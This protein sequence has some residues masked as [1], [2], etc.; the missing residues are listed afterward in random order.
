MPSQILPHPALAA[1]REHALRAAPVRTAGGD[2][3]VLFLSHSDGEARATVSSACA[4]DGAGAW[5]RL[6][7][8]YLASG[9]HARWLRLDW[10]ETVEETTWAGLRAALG[11]VKRNYF[12]YGIS[13]DGEFRHAFLEGEL[14]ANAML[15]GGSKEPAAI[16]NERNFRIYARK[17][18]GLEELDFAPGDPVWIFATKGVF[19]GEDGVPQELARD[20][21]NSGRRAVDTMDPALVRQLIAAGSAYLA[22]QVQPH[23]RFNYG[24]HPCFDRP[25]AAYNTLRHASSLYAMYEAWQVTRDPA[26]WQSCERARRHLVEDL[27]RPGEEGQPGAAFLVDERDEV[28]LGGNAVAILALLEHARISGSAAS[29]ELAERLGE[30]ILRMQ[31]RATGAFVH[32]LNYPALDVKEPFRIIYY[33]GEAAFA[34]IRLYDAT[35]NE[36]WLAAAERACDHFIRQDFA[37]LHDHWLGYFTAN[38][39][40]H[41]PEE[42][43][44]RFGIANF[45]DHLD[46][47]SQRITT[48]PTLLELMMA[49]HD[50][51]RIVHDRP[52]AQHL[53]ADVDLPKFYQALDHRARYLLNGH[54][55]PE[56]AM[57]FAKPS[58]IVGSFFIR[59]QSF[60]VR[61]DDV[62]HYLSGLVAYLRFL[63]SDEPRLDQSSGS[64][65]IETAKNGQWDAG[66]LR[67][68]TGGEWLTPPPP[69]WSA[70]GLCTSPQSFRE[71]DIVAV[72]APAE[73]VGVRLA[74]LSRVAST[75]AAWMVQDPAAVLGAGQQANG[76]APVL[77]VES[78]RSATMALARYA[79]DR[80]TGKVVAITG[81]ATQ[82]NAVAMLSGA[83][84]SFGSVA[85]TRH[86]GDLPSGFA[87]S[88]ATTPW[89]VDHLVLELAAGRLRQ[90]A[91]LV[92]PHVAVLTDLSSAQLEP[93]QD[94]A[95]IT[96]H[97]NAI[98]DA[99][100]PGG[101][102]VLCR[103]MVDW[104]GVNLAAR[105][106]GL[107]VI[108]YGVSGGCDVQLL[109][110]DDRTRTVNAR[111]ARRDFTYRLGMPG[112]RM[113]ADSL[114]ILA[115]VAALGHDP[116]AAAELLQHFTQFA[117]QNYDLA[118][119]SAGEDLQD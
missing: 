94:R 109:G 57:Y 66:H 27:I 61:I 11:D 25:I 46:F 32:V 71:N 105:V 69:G 9:S 70:R 51:L 14:N 118:P 83:L 59:H 47:V 4:A 100:D 113:T 2:R 34:L 16:L 73:D 63:S 117:P 89:D 22:G 65:G 99:V 17:R 90:N 103:E 35:G 49:S 10:I 79:R 39:V 119:E 110:Y 101:V 54:F 13:L 53:L 67:R 97:T 56:L 30:G 40:R 64:N 81:C 88:L 55:W 29:R 20:L 23:G 18:H 91:R 28:K 104:Q 15:Y 111:F 72:R 82:T 68:A 43:Y 106:R 102:V 98:F 92:R 77:R 75:P 116:V 108:N 114:A 52:E 60:R 80:M 50:L 1:L 37:K 112:D 115:A 84:Q 96:A 21:L 74:Q 44:F 3:A 33:E 76:A 7:E 36:R 24:W 45:A 107:S 12:R 48:F 42:R 38:L 78:V 93:G 8:Q 19:V 41:R 26:L 62:E 87:A 58:R 95:D 86:E 31:D 5:D 85:G 6:E